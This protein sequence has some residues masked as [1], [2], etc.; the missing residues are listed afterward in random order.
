MKRVYEDEKFQSFLSKREITFYFIYTTTY[1]SYGRC[2]KTFL[3]ERLV[4]SV[5]CAMKA[6]FKDRIVHEDILT[7]SLAEIEN[8][9]NSLPLAVIPLILTP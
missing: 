2:F 1:S 7:T 8:A 6:V 4:K 9:I 5:K 3:W